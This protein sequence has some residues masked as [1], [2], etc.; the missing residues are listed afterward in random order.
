MIARI[1]RGAVRQHDGAAYVT[2]MNETGVWMLHRDVE[3]KPEFVMFTLWRK[4]QE[5]SDLHSPR[6]TT[7]L[8]A[9]SRLSRG[10]L[11]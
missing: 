11:A 6:L 9:S 1:W 7:P 8:R 3:G 10:A 4:Q 2:H 5:A